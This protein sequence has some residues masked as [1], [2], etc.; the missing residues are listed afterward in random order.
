MRTL[1]TVL[2]DRHQLMLST[3]PRKDIAQALRFQRDELRRNLKKR[4]VIQSTFDFQAVWVSFPIQILYE[5]LLQKIFFA[6]G[7]YIRTCS[8]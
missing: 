3:K 6:V 7:L 4:K 8:S 1:F 2:I 5:R